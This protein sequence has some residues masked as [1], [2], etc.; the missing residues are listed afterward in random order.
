[1]SAALGR[2]IM[3]MLHMDDTTL[4][5]QSKVGLQSLTEKYMHFCKMCRMRPALQGSRNLTSYLPGGLVCKLELKGNPVSDPAD[6]P[7]AG[8]AP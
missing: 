1:M 3:T 6:S 5:A 7:T 4:V 2:W 8:E